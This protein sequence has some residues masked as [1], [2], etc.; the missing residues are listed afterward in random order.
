[1]VSGP[2]GRTPESDRRAEDAA[3][4]RGARPDAMVYSASP[5]ATTTTKFLVSIV[6]LRLEL[7]LPGLLQTTRKFILQGLSTHPSR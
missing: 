7:S 1:M 2:A 6:K 5:A 3:P 4:A